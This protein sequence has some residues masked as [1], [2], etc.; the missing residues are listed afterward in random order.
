MIKI[1]ESNYTK[2]GHEKIIVELLNQ[3]AMGIMGGGVSLADTVKKNLVQELEKR[4]GIHTVIAFAEDEP[5]GL[6][7]CIEGFSTFACKPLLNIHDIY[8]KPNYRGRGIAKQMLQKVEAIAL[9]R[10]C[11]K[12]TLEVLEKNEVGKGLYDSFGFVPYGLDPALGRALFL[13]KVLLAEAG[14]I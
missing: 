1:V 13:E 14:L 12:L 5:V 9:R 6:A 11:C 2:D 3:Y 10:G 7:I 4:D 8:V